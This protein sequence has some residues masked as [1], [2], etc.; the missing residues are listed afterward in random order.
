MR[1]YTRSQWIL[2]WFTL[3]QLIKSPLI[4]GFYIIRFCLTLLCLNSIKNQTLKRLTIVDVLKNN[5]HMTIIELNTIKTNP[6]KIIANLF[7]SNS[8]KLIFLFFWTITIRTFNISNPKI[9]LLIISALV[10][11]WTAGMVESTK[12]LLPIKL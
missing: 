7:C 11:T 8:P 6:V 10:N 1:K 2:W 9:K 12:Y 3:K 5:Y 4:E